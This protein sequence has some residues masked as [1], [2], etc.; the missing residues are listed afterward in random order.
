MTEHKSPMPQA[1]EVPASDQLLDKI[2]EKAVDSAQRAVEQFAKL[3]ALARTIE[4]SNS[5]LAERAKLLFAFEEIAS[6]AEA[7]A[8]LDVE[9]LQGLRNGQVLK[10]DLRRAHNEPG[11]SLPDLATLA[12]STMTK[13]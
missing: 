2:L 8:F 3:A 10:Q 9:L 4:Q 7:E 13:H 1:L 5:S 11:T 6:R 12:P